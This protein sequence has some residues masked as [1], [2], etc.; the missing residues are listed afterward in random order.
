MPF[1]SITTAP[2][3]RGPAATLLIVLAVAAGAHP[4]SAAPPSP[5]A[6]DYARADAQTIKA[7]T[8]EIIANPRFAPRMTLGQ[9]L[10]EKL[11]GWDRP[12]VHLPKGIGT[13]F[14]IAIT[15]WCLLT[16][17]AILGHLV[18]TIWLFAHPSGT[19][20]AGGSGLAS[21]AGEITCPDELWRQSQQL[22]QRGAFRGAVGVL[23]LA[24]L[25]HLEATKVLSFHKS[26][27]NGEYIREYPGHRAGRPEFVQF[28]ATFERD[29][30]G[31]LEIHGQTY[32]A[33]SVLAK[34]IIGD[35]SQDA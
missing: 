25:R 29:I 35:V 10:I 17:V 20:A 8:Q 26:K 18:W 12:K 5:A 19:R 23:L 30:Y 34:R 22:A 24:L 9:W 16:L 15:T 28:I 2:C 11:R 32:E 6:S 33:M 13:F 4:S 27:T 31:G 7:H 21:D 14:S 3:I 1:G